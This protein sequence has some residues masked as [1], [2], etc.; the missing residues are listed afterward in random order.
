MPADSDHDEHVSWQFL[1]E[2]A[3]CGYV[4][5]SADLQITRVNATALAW[6]GYESPDLLVGQSISVLM[7]ESDTKVLSDS[8]TQLRTGGTPIQNPVPVSFHGRLKRRTG[9]QFPALFHLSLDTQTESIC[10][11][12]IFHL[13]QFEDLVESLAQSNAQLKS[14]GTQRAWRVQRLAAIAEA[15]TDAI[16]SIDHDQNVT[17]ANPAAWKLF[18]TDLEGMLDKPLNQ[19]I[20]DRFRD[21]HHQHV[22]E[23]GKSG[24]S[25]RRMAG[26]LT[27]TGLR[28]DGSEFPLEA[29]ISH[30]RIED[31]PVYTVILRDVTQ[32]VAADQEL[33]QTREKLQQLTARLRSVREEEQRH[34]AREL[35]DDV[36]QRLSA[37]RM[38][39]AALRDAMPVEQP[40]L[41]DI[42]ENMD[43]LVNSTVVAVR[44][45]ATG[46]RPRILD[47]LGLAPALETFLKDI[48]SRF[49]I[50]FEI[51][52][53]EQIALPDDHPIVLFRIVQEATHNIVK[54]ARAKN[55]SVTLEERNGQWRLAIRD[56]GQGMVAGDESKP[57]AL[58]V[59]G[60]RERVAGIGGE[61]KIHSAPNQGT[62]IECLF[63]IPTT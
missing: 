48:E 39:I 59:V 7:D 40:N 44:R 56:N 21:A 52:V 62:M 42:I 61:M 28:A 10:H 41:F 2:N 55:A 60:M 54:H 47:E 49:G 11:L 20:P 4:T 35:H 23:F 5:L 51:S 12:A 9:H 25:S 29:S 33:L 14:E 46:L 15:I 34:V 36:G 43:E 26:S 1:Y 57:N 3:A 31:Q 27:V 17:F 19:F 53:D 22:E 30:I 58:G 32:R 38:D 24:V 50:Q 37:L 18:R 45:L 13:H 63:P 6:L 8:H 16:I